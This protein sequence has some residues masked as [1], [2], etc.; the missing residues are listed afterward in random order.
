MKANRPTIVSKEMASRVRH[1]GGFVLAG[2][3]AFA[4]DA[5]ILEVL[6]RAAELSPFLARPVGISVGMVV[7]WLVNRRVTFDVRTRPTV[8]EFLHFAAVSWTAQLFNYLIFAAILAVWPATPPFIA[9][10]VASAI[11]MFSSYSGFRYV[12]FRERHRAGTSK[13]G[14]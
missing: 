9:L 1:Y 12:V 7:S 11:S 3:L 2:L 4:A 10:V 14:P 5:A 6:V 13:S 8:A